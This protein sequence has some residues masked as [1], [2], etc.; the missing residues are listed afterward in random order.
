M[1]QTQT[2]LFQLASSHIGNRGTLTNPTKDSKRWASFKVWEPFAV[3]LVLAAG[4]WPAARAEFKLNLHAER[5]DNM[6]WTAGDPAPGHKYTYNLP[7]DMLRP[8]QLSSGMRFLLG[9]RGDDKVLHTGDPAPILEYTKYE[10]NYGLYDNDLFITVSYVLAAF[11]ANSLSGRDR[12]VVRLGERA[13]RMI[14]ET[15]SAVLNVDDEPVKAISSWHR[16]RGV[17][18]A[19]EPSRY[20]YPYGELFNVGSSANVS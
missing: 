19:P 5:S 16:A 10:T 18:R 2:E 9:V 15:R 17:I 8:R 1:A 3:K 13:N 11:C 14:M 4:H 20:V 7:D 6:D 12:D